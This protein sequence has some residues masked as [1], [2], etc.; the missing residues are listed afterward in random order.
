MRQIARER[1]MIIPQGLMFLPDGKA[2]IMDQDLYRHTLDNSIVID[3]VDMNRSLPYSGDNH[4]DN[5]LHIEEQKVSRNNHKDINRKPS[6][7]NQ[8]R[9]GKSQNSDANN[10][11]GAFQEQ[12][13]PGEGN[14]ESFGGLPS[15][16]EDSNVFVQPD[17]QPQDPELTGEQKDFLG[18]LD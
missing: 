4:N 13:Q 15:I 18:L 16:A 2:L 9:L 6:Q 5:A 12:S 14:N 1:N 8:K 11:F 10:N 7:A 17:P 3:L